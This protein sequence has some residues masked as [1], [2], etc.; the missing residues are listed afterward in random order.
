MTTKELNA[1][2]ADLTGEDLSLIN[3]IGFS[4]VDPFLVDFDPEPNDLPASMVDWDS[5]YLG[6][7]ICPFEVA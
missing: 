2:I 1:A 6:D 3:K 5:P 4:E 7:T